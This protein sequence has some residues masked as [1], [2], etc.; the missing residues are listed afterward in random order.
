[1]HKE[2]RVMICPDSRLTT[3]RD[4][5][6]FVADKP[7][8]R[9]SNSSLGIEIHRTMR[10]QRASSKIRSSLLTANCKCLR[11]LM[12][13]SRAAL[14]S[15]SERITSP[16]FSLDLRP[17]TEP[18]SFPSSRS[19]MWTQADS[20]RLLLIRREIREPCQFGL[21]RSAYEVA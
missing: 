14:A 15:S 2:P 6:C 5:S 12:R 9:G 13:S 16:T 19:L 18:H 7:D 3:T 4:E 11:S 8:L 1:M 20:K 10:H 17:K 21:Y